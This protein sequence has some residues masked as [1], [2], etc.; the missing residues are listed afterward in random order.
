MGK[1]ASPVDLVVIG[2]GSAGLAAA[3]TAREAGLS[4]TLLEAS[5]RIGGRAFTDTEAFTFPFDLGCHWMHSASLNP[6]V[7]IA[8]SLGHAY[9]KD[10]FPRRI[11]LGDRWA[12]E[13]ECR[14]R[15][16]FAERCY[17][18][19][20]A[21][22]DAGR[23]VAVTEVTAREDRWT[24]M[25]DLWTSMYASVDSDQVST[26]DSSSYNDT[27]ENWPLVDGYGS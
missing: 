7:E 24:P 17:E 11:H 14:E 23:D 19:I 18:A 13:A 3:R 2:A 8:E 27:D 25:F 5:H 26:V 15:E 4:V 9:T 20:K 1:S 6:Y 12:T 21:A 22:A 16:A 10:G